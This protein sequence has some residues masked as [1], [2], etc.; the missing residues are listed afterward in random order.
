MA[1]CLDIYL[2]LEEILALGLSHLTIDLS[3]DDGIELS[4]LSKCYTTQTGSPPQYS[5]CEEAFWNIPPLL[6]LLGENGAP[7]LNGPKLELTRQS[8]SQLQELHLCPS[9]LSEQDP[10]NP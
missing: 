6:L 8:L 2:P 1:T 7:E 3:K 9:Y 5:C 4:P 10:D